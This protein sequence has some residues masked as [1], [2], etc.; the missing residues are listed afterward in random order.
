M[1]KKKLSALISAADDET[2]KKVADSHP[3]LSSAQKDELYARI[4]A[5]A[6]QTHEYADRVSGVEVRHGRGAS[7][8]VGFAAALAL[9]LA[10]LG[11]GGLL[12]KQRMAAAPSSEIEDGVDVVEEETEAVTEAETE[13]VTEAETGYVSDS[14]TYYAAIASDFTERFIN[15]EAVLMCGQ[16]ECDPNDTVTFYVWDDTDEEWSRKYGG[17]R[18]FCKVTDERFGSCQDIFDNYAQ[19]IAVASS[20]TPFEEATSLDGSTMKSY[21]G[22]DVSEFEPGSTVHFN[23]KS[24]YSDAVG[25]L[26]RCPY[27]DYNGSLYVADYTAGNKVEARFTSAP[28]ISNATAGGFTVSRYMIPAY[29]NYANAKY[30]EEKIYSFILSNGEWKISGVETGAQVEYLAAIGIQCYLEHRPEY[31]DIDID[32]GPIMRSIEVTS[33]DYGKCIAEV[34]GV[35]KDVNGT[36]AVEITATCSVG[37]Q[38]FGVGYADITRL[39][40][41]DGTLKRPSVIWAEKVAAGEVEK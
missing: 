36:D 18:T 11:G 30:G 31:N 3:M 5:R 41:Y 21:L 2:L 25:A 13:A 35:L 8:F 23:G 14:D 40:E 22:G 29:M 26:I 33:Y 19:Y 34:H 6:G 10:G 12:M 20:G 38:S 17:E 24:N 28:V 39:N 15:A 4:A 1:D 32:S 16:A 7:R 27:I 37:K 9:V